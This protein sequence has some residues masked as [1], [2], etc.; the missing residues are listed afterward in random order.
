MS[1]GSD[2]GDCVDGGS[3][4]GHGIVFS[5]R[6]FNL[7]DRHDSGGRWWYA[8]VKIKANEILLCIYG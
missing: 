5:I 3:G 6:R 7:H 8:S 2:G 4:G 1:T